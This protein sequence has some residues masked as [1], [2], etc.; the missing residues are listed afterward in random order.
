M[1]RGLAAAFRPGG[2]AARMSGTLPGFAAGAETE[3]YGIGSGELAQPPTSEVLANAFSSVW[4]EENPTFRLFGAGR[5]ALADRAATPDSEDRLLTVE[6]AN[7][8]YGIE[9]ALTFSAPL[10]ES[11]ARELRQLA[12]E[13]ARRA[14]I[15]A[16]ASSGVAGWTARTGLS[17]AAGMLDPLNIASAFV[18]VVGEARAAAWLGTAATRLGRVGV[19]AR[20]G[21]IEGTAGALMLEPL[22]Y[23][24]HLSEARNDYGMA[25]SLLNVAFG[26][27][28]GALLHS[29][30]RAVIDGFRGWN[31]TPELARD[32]HETSV[33][34][35]VAQLER[36]EPVN[37]EPLFRAGR[38]F[39]E[40]TRRD[41]L[42]GSA[43]RVEFGPDGLPRVA[44]AAPRL[45]PED[46]AALPRTEIEGMAALRNDVANREAVRAPVLDED[47]ELVIA[48]SRDEQRSLN[49]RLEREGHGGVEWLPMGDEPGYY[50]A[51]RVGGVDVYRDREGLPR[52]YPSISRAKEAA[53]QIQGS[54]WFPVEI[55]EEG[56][57]VLLRAP[58]A[59]RAR[60]L[61][62]RRGLEIGPA[63]LR[64]DTTPPVMSSDEVRA[65]FQDVTRSMT[66][67]RP[68][69]ARAV[70]AAAEARTRSE[71]GARVETPVART[72]A[73]ASAIEA[74]VAETDAVLAEFVRTGRITQA[75]ADAVR[76]PEA[77][78]RVRERVKGIEAAAA[79]LIA[80]GA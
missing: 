39:P 15:S 13:R 62:N 29:G 14:D 74:R 55:P 53:K 4:H 1:G 76:A 47:G 38:M 67:L 79:C 40:P 8:E 64:P 54:G 2:R 27:G 24:L 58:Q 57:V 6:E 26:A 45:T 17:L 51:A 41:Q 48:F 19:S 42:L 49:A 60:L 23:G 35:A 46:V 32:I 5:R 34:A 72:T 33:R 70:A 75:E 80:N 16:R 61:A 77:E 43:A 21:A 68:D 37:V 10:A 66:A 73:E 20:I 63:F 22:N 65:L 44:D 3:L 50:A 11:S 69:E 28:F 56:G 31:P 18:P 9:G 7:K 12:Q 36:G 59:E 25:D 71:A 78:A 52:V 30:G